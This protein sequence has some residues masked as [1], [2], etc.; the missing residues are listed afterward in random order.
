MA[1][2]NKNNNRDRN[3]IKKYLIPLLIL[4]VENENFN[5]KDKKEDLIEENLILKKSFYIIMEKNYK[6]LYTVKEQKVLEEKIDKS[7]K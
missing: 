5:N 1:D 3:K 4:V 7:F 6:K 2:N